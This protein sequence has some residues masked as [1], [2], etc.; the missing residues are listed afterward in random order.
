MSIRPSEVILA[1]CKL[2]RLEPEDVLGPYNRGTDKSLYTARMGIV[3]ALRHIAGLSYPETARA[4]GYRGHSAAHR[5]G[6]RFDTIDPLTQAD[7][8]CDVLL[9]ISEANGERKS[10][11]LRDWVEEPLCEA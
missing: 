11:A 4:I 9:T 8:L 2:T 3:A 10:G 6:Q 1:A 7:W 5:M